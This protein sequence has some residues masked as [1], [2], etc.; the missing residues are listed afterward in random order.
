ML[1]K[2]ADHLKAK[3][4]RQDHLSRQLKIVKVFD[5][6]REEIKKTFPDDRETKP[7][8]LKNK[9]LTVRTDSAVMANELRFRERAILDRLNQALSKETVKRIIYRF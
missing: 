1:K 2:L 9:V 4:S 6:Y 7:V 8:S 3:Y 5:I